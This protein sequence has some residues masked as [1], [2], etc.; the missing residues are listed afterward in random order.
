MGRSREGGA[1][2]QGGCGA[3]L[4]GG[5]N[6]GAREATGGGRTMSVTMRAR[7]VSALA[8]VLALVAAGAAVARAQGQ[9]APP[10]KT[11]TGQTI[12]I[13]GQ[14][15]TPQVVT[16]RPREVPVYMPAALPGAVM[17]SGAWPSA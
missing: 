9:Q 10:K 1:H 15:P 13:R 14:A 5:A 4:D 16:V 7:P 11:T 12:E 2:G 8:V 17:A 3:G 6:A